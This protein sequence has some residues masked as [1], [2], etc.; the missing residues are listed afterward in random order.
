MRWLWHIIVLCLGTVTV[1]ARFLTVYLP[2]WY[3]GAAQQ[4]YT[5]ILT[6]Q[7]QQITIA[8][9]PC[10]IQLEKVSFSPTNGIIKI[11]MFI[12]FTKAETPFRLEIAQGETRN[13]LTCIFHLTRVPD[14]Y[15]IEKMQSRFIVYNIGDQAFDVISAQ[16]VEFV[17][18]EPRIM[19]GTFK[20]GGEIRINNMPTIKF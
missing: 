9:Q 17:T 20:A 2:A 6:N 10:F 5:L 7:A 3:N 19:K 14:Q 11:P 12:Q 18:K 1:G 15:L 8:K 16:G 13:Y 4:P